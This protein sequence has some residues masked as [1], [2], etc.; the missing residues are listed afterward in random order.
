MSDSLDQRRKALEE[1]YFQ[2]L[3]AEALARLNSKKE[4]GT[5]RPSPITGK[6]MEQV[7]LHGIVIDRCL[8][9][10][11]IFLDAGELE[12]IIKASSATDEASK[13]WLSGFLAKLKS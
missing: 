1:S 3:E 2:K 10:G 11:G 4:T 6:P 12:E 7:T 9:S 8:D 13:G 5:V